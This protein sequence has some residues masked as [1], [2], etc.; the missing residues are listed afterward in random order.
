MFVITI[1]ELNCLFFTSLL[2]FSKK[3]CIKIQVF[4]STTRINI[5]PIPQFQF[6]IY[7]MCSTHTRINNLKYAYFQFTSILAF[8][9]TWGY[10]QK[11]GLQRTECPDRNKFLSLKHDINWNKITLDSL[12]TFPSAPRRL[13]NTS[14]EP[15]RRQKVVKKF[16]V[17]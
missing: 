8:S 14:E 17:C 2:K 3:Y 7:N 1:L 16:V 15:R 12:L 9:W 5:C 11:C 13:Q 4:G 10:H 6:L